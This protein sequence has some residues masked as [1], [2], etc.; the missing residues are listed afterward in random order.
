MSCVQVLSVSDDK[1]EPGHVRC[2]ISPLTLWSTASAYNTIQYNTHNVTSR[3]L[4]HRA[5]E[6][7]SNSSTQFVHKLQRS[8]RLGARSVAGTSAARYTAFLNGWAGFNLCVCAA[9]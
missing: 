7:G 5:W 6:S 4:S 9:V 3:Q 1:T 8:S 2:W